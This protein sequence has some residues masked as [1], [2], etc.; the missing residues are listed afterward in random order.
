MDQ[1][2]LS[3]L[4]LVYLY[5][6]SVVLIA[7]RSTYLN[8]RGWNRKFIHIMIGNIVFLWWIFDGQVRHGL[9]GRGP[10]IPILLYSSLKGDRISQRTRPGRSAPPW[11]RPP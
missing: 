5:V 7:M 6:G 4:L 2:D 9:P 11:P 3:G 1:A 10:F 8:D